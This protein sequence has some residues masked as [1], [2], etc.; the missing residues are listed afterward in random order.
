VPA[1]RFLFWN[2]NRKPPADLIGQIAHAHAAEVVILAESDINLY[3][4]NK[5]RNSLRERKRARILGLGQ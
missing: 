1:S 3:L 5:K 2:I 4:V